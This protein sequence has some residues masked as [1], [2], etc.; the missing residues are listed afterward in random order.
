MQSGKLHDVF[1]MA[2]RITWLD[3]QVCVC[4]LEINNNN[5]QVDKEGKNKGL[6]VI[7]YSHPLEAVQAVS[8]FDKQNLTDRRLGVKMV[9]L[10][11]FYIYKPLIIYRINSKPIDRN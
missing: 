7:E 3:V 5:K 11:E 1:S 4:E 10:E 6:A 2:G 8:M 9:C